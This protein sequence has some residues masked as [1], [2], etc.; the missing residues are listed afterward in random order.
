MWDSQGRS[1]SRRCRPG[2]RSSCRVPSPPCAAHT[3]LSTQLTFLS[4]KL[5]FLSSKPTFLNR[6]PH[7]LHPFD[8]GCLPLNHS[9]NSVVQWRIL[10]ECAQASTDVD[11]DSG[12]GC[13]SL[14]PQYTATPPRTIHAVHREGEIVPSDVCVHGRHFT[15][16]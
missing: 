7:P 5:T 10:Q 13:A 6:C 2:S 14:P 1:R 8:T 12:A 15:G 3:F 4:L 9:G 11:I 16:W